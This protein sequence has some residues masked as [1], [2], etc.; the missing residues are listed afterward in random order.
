MLDTLGAV[1]TA[2]LTISPLLGID[3]RQQA[4]MFAEAQRVWTLHG[5]TLREGERDN[6]DR[7]LVVKSDT[8]ARAEN[9]APGP[10]LGWVPFVAGKA[11]RVVF[12]RVA[13]ASVL[14]ADMSPGT[15]P[16]GL[17]RFLVGRLL[18][19]VLA[20]E[21]GH[22]LLGSAQHQAN[23]LMRAQYQAR[24]VL[25]SAPASYTLDAGERARL[26]A[27]GAEPRLARR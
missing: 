12:L 1:L 23:G 3:A 22:I 15:R 26:F 21:I 20:H 27:G 2:C 13:R 7:L 11:R 6:C 24:D 14:T 25:K 10:A 8:E 17:T 18:G 19:R 16:D 4:E 9:I 5:V